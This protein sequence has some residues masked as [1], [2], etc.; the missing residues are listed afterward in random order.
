MGSDHTFCKQHLR[1]C[2]A[3]P[4]SLD[5]LES[6][7]AQSYFKYIS[8]YSD[9]TSRLII[10]NSSRHVLIVIIFELRLNLS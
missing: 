6:I 9:M 3:R 10:V 1:Y 5:D 4:W 7:L 2:L 8:H